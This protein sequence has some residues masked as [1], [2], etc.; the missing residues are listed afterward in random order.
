[1]LLNMAI[2]N[3]IQNITEL[4]NVFFLLFLMDV[5]NVLICNIFKTTLSV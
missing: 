5:S 2:E 4:K 3:I 1:M